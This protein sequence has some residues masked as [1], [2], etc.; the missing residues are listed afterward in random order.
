MINIYCNTDRYEYDIRALVMGFFPGETISYHYEMNS[1][2]YNSD[3]GLNNTYDR[4]VMCTDEAGTGHISIYIEL[5]EYNMSVKADNAGHVTYM[6]D[7]SEPSV[8]HADTNI[9]GRVKDS[10]SDWSGTDNARDVIFSKI[11]RDTLKRLIYRVLSASLNRTLAWGTLTGVRPAKIPIK[12]L[13]EGYEPN[14]IIDRIVK[15]Y[16]CS[17]EKARL[18]TQVAE[19]ELKILKDIG[20]ETGYSI[21]IGIPFCPTVCTYCS[22]SSTA[23]DGIPGADELMD[24]Y[25]TALESEC[26]AVKEMCSGRKLTSIYIGGGTPTALNERNLKRL[27]DIVQENYPV[28]SVF[29]YTVEAGRPDSINE[30]KL[31]ILR[32]GG[33]TRISVNPQSMK[34]ETLVS[35][36]RRHTVR[37]TIEVYELAR[38]HG[39]DNIN[40]DLIAGLQGETTEDFA[41]TLEYIDKLQPDS[42]TVHSLVVKRAS[43]Y[44][45][46]RELEKGNDGDRKAL[47][48]PDNKSVTEMMLDMASEYAESAGYRP[49]YM[50]RQKNKAG[51]GDNPVLENIG[52]AKSGKEGIYNILIMEER[53]TIIA[54][55]AGASSKL[56]SNISLDDNTDQRI[57]RIANVKNVREYIERTDEMIERKKRWMDA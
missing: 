39:F 47:D 2:I 49:Y 53:Q 17:V 31:D 54:L 26:R 52:Y 25:I 27:M 29:E 48:R 1:D 43:E 38:K 55:G 8:I 10:S 9:A 18:C 51:L 6:E 5:G 28:D 41:K 40:M 4:D 19:T 46:Q 23:V 16:Y 35:I 34:Q 45:K 13:I 20:Y 7:K 3:A 24:E 30:A 11:Y 12:Y 42:F 44:R 15:E 14:N 56:V 33:V 37:Q 32:A 22:F 50:Y 36:G 21:Y 57:E